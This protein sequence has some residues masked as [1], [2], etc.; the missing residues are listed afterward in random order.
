LA[1]WG[2]ARWRPA[3]STRIQ[4]LLTPIS[5]VALDCPTDESKKASSDDDSPF[6]RFIAQEGELIKLKPPPKKRVRRMTKQQNQEKGKRKS[7]VR[8]TRR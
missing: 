3:Q 1:W 4:R 8:S 2:G 7:S 5:L 6:E